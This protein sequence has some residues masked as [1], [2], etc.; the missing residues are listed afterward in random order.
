MSSNN[1]IIPISYSADL[2]KLPT[3]IFIPPPA[4]FESTIYSLT[5]RHSKVEA[6]NRI[7]MDLIDKTHFNIPETNCNKNEK[8]RNKDK[9]NNVKI[10]DRLLKLGEM[11]KRKRDEIIKDEKLKENDLLMK[12]CTFYPKIS[13]NS[14]EITLNSLN[15]RREPI[16]SFSIKWVF[17]LF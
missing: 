9:F 2:N 1:S 8:I 16:E 14:N 6:S 4:I 7:Y 10:E 11:T 17:L 12:E 15:T 5:S 13:D 3:C